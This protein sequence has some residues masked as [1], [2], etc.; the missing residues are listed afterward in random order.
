MAGDVSRRSYFRLSLAAGPAVLALYPP[1][2]A[3]GC[4]RYLA[5]TG[6]L[7]GAGVRVPRVLDQD[8][9]AGWTL[10]EDLGPRTLYEE[11][12]R[13]WSEL[14]P[15]F[16]AA[17]DAGRRIA[18]LPPAAVADLNPRLDRELL[19]RE[20]DQTR[21]AFLEPLGLAGDPEIARALATLCERLGAEPPVPC[22]RDFGARNL[23]PLESD[24]PGE[25]SA[26][27]GDAARIGVL[28]HQDLRLGPPA[29]DLASLLNDS[30]FP[31]ADLE[32]ALLAAAGQ[33]DRE[34]YH[35]A[36]TQRTLKAVGS[37]A[38]FAR[39]GSDRHLPLVAPTLGRA[40]G[41]L[42]RVPETAPL[43]ARFDALWAPVAEGRIALAPALLD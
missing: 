37:Y 7:A 38:A 16:V 14:A 43:A 20:L 6:L 29:Y 33:V 36:A 12:G 8:C 9:R 26:E 27:A 10:L 41:H 15:F 4:T 32:E 11:K 28:D 21:T 18:S 40:L 1:D 5:T 2:L 42:R 3:A 39:R 23:M 19:A 34:S 35:R 17:V 13:P 30:L 22:H 25:R 31:P 24:A